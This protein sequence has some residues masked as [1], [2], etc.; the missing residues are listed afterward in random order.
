[1]EKEIEAAKELMKGLDLLEKAKGPYVDVQIINS[2]FKQ[3]VAGRLRWDE[4]SK[5]IVVENVKDQNAIDFLMGSGAS[6]MSPSGFIRPRDGLKY[7][8]GLSGAFSQ[9]SRFAVSELKNDK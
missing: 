8:R 7:L 4:A 2:K 1:M 6:F 5:K 9:S 3:I